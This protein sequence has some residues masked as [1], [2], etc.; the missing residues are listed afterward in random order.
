MAHEVETMFYTERETPWHGLGISVKESLNSKDALV[1]SG[2]DW[3]VIQ[4]P[5]KTNDKIIEGYV[6]NVRNTDEKCL[7]IVSERYKLVQN[8]EA[9]EF[10][11]NLLGNDVTYDTAGSL[12]GGKKIWLLAK[13]PTRK[14]LGDEYIP[15]TVFSNTHDGSGSIRGAITPTRVV[16][17]NTLNLALATAKRQWS[18]KHMGNIDDKLLEA[19][20]TLELASNYMDNLEI[21]ANELARQKITEDYLTNFV[22]S[23]FPYDTNKGKG[24][25]RKNENI[26]VIR[27]NFYRAYNVDD[28]ANFRNTKYAVINAVSDLVTHATPIRQSDTF[29]ENLFDKVIGGHDIIDQAYKLLQ[30]A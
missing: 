27:S 10:T 14:I 5:I 13:M 4:Q 17:N 24:N 9:F 15:Y 11:D 22:N 6:A 29:K 20:T 16:C 18:T 7:G 23:L 3:Q 26:K 25:S 28:L 1:A 12:F 2:L 19:Q 21:T 8:V 30:V